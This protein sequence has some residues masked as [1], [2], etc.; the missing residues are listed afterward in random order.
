MLS[1][2]PRR[3]FLVSAFPARPPGHPP[4]RLR[5]VRYST[6][7]F[8]SAAS[9]GAWNS[10]TSRTVSTCSPDNWISIFWRP[11]ASSS[12]SLIVS[13]IASCCRSVCPHSPDGSG[14][15]VSHWSTHQ[16]AAYRQYA[17]LYCLLV[18]VGGALLQRRGLKPHFL[19]TYLNIVA[20]VLFSGTALRRVRSAGLRP[21]V[22]RSACRLWRVSRLGSHAGSLP[23]L[24]MPLSTATWASVRSFLRGVNDETAVLAISSSPESRCSWCWS[25][26]APLRED[27]ELYSAS[28]EETLRARKL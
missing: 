1:C 21:M 17:L 10:L 5:R 26:R 24:P 16:D 13:T 12:S 20:N 4:K 11:P 28:S 2:N 14:S 25:D 8:T 7:C 22:S 15:P 19:G 6:T 18:G 27:G 9:S 23:S 3:L